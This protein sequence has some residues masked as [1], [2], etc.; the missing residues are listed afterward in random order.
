MVVGLWVVSPTASWRGIEHRISNVQQLT[1]DLS[2]VVTIGR[3]R[4]LPMRS[5]GGIWEEAFSMQRTEDGG[6][7]DLERGRGKFGTKFEM[8]FWVGGRNPGERAETGSSLT[9]AQSV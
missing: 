4:K 9:E 1:F 5:L 3:S 7:R 6:E 8:K 2:F